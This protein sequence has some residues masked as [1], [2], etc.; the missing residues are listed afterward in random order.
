MIYFFPDVLVSTRQNQFATS[1]GKRLNEYT[2]KIFYPIN[3]LIMNRILSW[4]NPIE[5]SKPTNIDDFYFDLSKK[6]EPFGS[7][8]LFKKLI[9]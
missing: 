5:D 9:F 8:F 7:F 2:G 3:F 1:F 4:K 6:K